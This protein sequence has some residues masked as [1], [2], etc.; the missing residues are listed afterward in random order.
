MIETKVGRAFT[1]L[2]VLRCYVLYRY[3]NDSVP[4]HHWF[5]T[6]GVQSQQC[7]G[8]LSPRSRK[9]LLTYF[10][11]GFCAFTVTLLR[12]ETRLLLVETLN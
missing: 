7:V 3:P 12:P 5:W 4:F 9:N 8:I 1:Q 11:G 6:W 10:G 2:D